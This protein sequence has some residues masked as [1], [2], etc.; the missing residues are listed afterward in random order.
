ME[1]YRNSCR[2]VEDENS[3]QAVKFLDNAEIRETI[4]LILRDQV[5]A[6]TTT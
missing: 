1:T 6:I 3:G 2:C 4:T 5:Y